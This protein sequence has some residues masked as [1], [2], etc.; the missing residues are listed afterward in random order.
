[1]VM[2]GRK[3]KSKGTKLAEAKM[4][5]A[6]WLADNPDKAVTMASGP[7]KGVPHVALGNF[8][9][10]NI[11]FGIGGLPFG[12]VIEIYGPESAGK[13]TWAC[14]IVAA[15]QRAGHVASYIDTEHAFDPDYFEA[16]GGSLDK[17]RFCF[18]QPESGEEAF[19]ISVSQLRAGWPGVMVF[20]SVAN[21]VPREE[22]DGEMDTKGMGLQARMMAKGLRKITAFASK[23]KCLVIFINQIRHKIG[24]L[25]GSPETT[26]GGNALK[27]YASMRFDIRAVGKIKVDGEVVGNKTRIRCVKNKMAAPFKEAILE[28][29]FGK[30]IVDA[31]SLFE[32]A[33]LN[34]IGVSRKNNS[35][36]LGGSERG[37]VGKDAARREFMA[38]P[39]LQAEVEERALSRIKRGKT[40]E[41]PVLERE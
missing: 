3:K 11:V 27:F 16:L 39:Y 37:V 21:M 32:I 30:G 15:F 10:D 13:T 34:N 23:R 26:P 33:Y 4:S 38:D 36:F 24:V 25:F 22:L 19:N 14:Q 1:M 41:V 28:M 9:L 35:W 5:L 7:R 6:D 8:I 2:Q 29:Y 12:R 40:L 20:D 31:A 17:D 18:S